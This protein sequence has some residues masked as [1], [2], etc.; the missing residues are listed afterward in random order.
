MGVFHLNSDENTHKIAGFEP[1]RAKSFTYSTAITR[2]FHYGTAGGHRCQSAKNRNFRIS[3]LQ[4][5][6][7]NSCALHQRR[8]SIDLV[9]SNVLFRARLVFQLSFTFSESV[10]V[11]R[12]N[13]TFFCKN[14]VRKLRSF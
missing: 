2:L 4:G 10:V 6:V 12:V 7:L 13:T 14:E 9:Y 1:P 11:V 3:E 8:F 5:S